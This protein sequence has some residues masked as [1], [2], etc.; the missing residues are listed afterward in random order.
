[1]SFSPL[2]VA[3]VGLVLAAL[4]LVTAL[5]MFLRDYAFRPKAYS[6]NQFALVLRRLGVGQQ[7]VAADRRLGANDQQPRP[8]G[9]LP[10]RVGTSR[11]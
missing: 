3:S 11:G 4:V 1:M 8:R 2:L 10:R 7:L 9:R 5:V 6:P